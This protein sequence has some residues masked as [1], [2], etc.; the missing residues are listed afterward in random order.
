MI[1]IHARVTREITITDEQAKRLAQYLDMEDLG[2]GY[3]G[4]EVNID[5]ILDAFTIGIDA[6]NYDDAGYIPGEWLADD[7]YRGK[8]LVVPEVDIEL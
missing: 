1:K 6:G 5:D 7:L 8:S 2:S 3:Q 4:D